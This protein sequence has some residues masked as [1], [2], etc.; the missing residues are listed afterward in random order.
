MAHIYKGFY[1]HISFNIVYLMNII[2][3]FEC[4]GVQVW[5]L[6]AAEVFLSMLVYFPERNEM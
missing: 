1:I 2:L 3:L 4:P 5:L 6:L